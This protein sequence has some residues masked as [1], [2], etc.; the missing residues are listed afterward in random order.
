MLVLGVEQVRER[1]RALA[2]VSASGVGYATLARSLL[3]Q[4]TVPMAVGVVLAMLGGGALA[5]LVM[6]LI[7][8][9]M[10]FDWAGIGLIT[11]AAGALTLVVT[12]LSLPALRAAV[13]V[14]NLRTE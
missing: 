10:V 8:R 11:G 12:L 2:A 1:R 6:R 5:A 9:P 14:R 13:S 7:H 4:N 3:W